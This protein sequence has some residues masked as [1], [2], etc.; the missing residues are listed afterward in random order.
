MVQQVWYILRKM[1]VEDGL[2]QYSQ[3]NTLVSIQLLI[4]NHLQI[5]QNEI[6]MKNPIDSF[7]KALMNW[8]VSDDPKWD[9]D[10]VVCTVD[11]KLVNCETWEEEKK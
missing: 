5:F 9:P 8:L 6:P 7:Y 2:R 4:F 1:I 11:D 3:E 10:N